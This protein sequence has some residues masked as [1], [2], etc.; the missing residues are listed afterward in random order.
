MPGTNE[1]IRGARCWWDFH[2]QMGAGAAALNFP[3]AA[4]QETCCVYIIISRNN[5]HS[6][7]RGKYKERQNNKKNR[8]NLRQWSCSNEKERNSRRTASQRAC[9]R[10][11]NWLSRDINTFDWS[12]R[13]RLNC[14][15][16]WCPH[17]Q[18]PPNLATWPGSASFSF[19][20]II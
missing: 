9:G 14:Q 13:R 3:P 15:E 18:R 5:H 1:T 6:T 16:F 7:S 10:C 19:S 20:I 11:L 17:R 8:G 4:G 12:E 2:W